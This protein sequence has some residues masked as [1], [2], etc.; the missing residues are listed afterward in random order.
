MTVKLAVFDCDGT[1]SD[2]QAGVV[3]AMEAAFAEVGETLPRRVQV[4]R[5]VG[6]SL[7]QA[8][9]HLAPDLPDDRQLAVVQ[10][11]KD[12]FRRSRENGSLREPLFDGMGELLHRLHGGGWTLGV[13]TGKSDRG[14]TSTLATHGLAHL[15]A[16]THTADRHPSKPHPSMLE[17]AM[18]DVLAEPHGTCMIGDT[19]FD[20]Q[21]AASAGV[22]A[23]GVAWGYH[24]PEELLAAGAVAV[25]DTMAELERLIDG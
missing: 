1:L 8:I 6:L 18:A 14:L 12:A 4:R 13:A 21:M 16:T 23:I 7:P 22:R 15:F 10:A 5:I 20:M 11:Y 25:A 9:R 19:V 3:N 2:G 24:E 17:A